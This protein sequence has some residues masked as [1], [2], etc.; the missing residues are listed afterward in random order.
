M[1]KRKFIRTENFNAVFA[2]NW[3]PVVLEGDA[4]PPFARAI[5]EAIRCCIIASGQDITNRPL[6]WSSRIVS[7]G[8]LVGGVDIYRH[9]P[10]DP[11]PLNKDW[12]AIVS[13]D[14][15][16]TLAVDGPHKDQEHWLTKVP[17]RY[18]GAKVIGSAGDDKKD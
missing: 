13:T 10:D 1:A 18:S 2:E 9:S 15:P 12:Y 3:N 11:V 5:P 16:D 8:Y 7:S 6:P 4:M 17:E 14:D